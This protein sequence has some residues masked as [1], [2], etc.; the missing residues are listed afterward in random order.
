MVCIGFMIL[1]HEIG[2]VEGKAVFGSQPNSLI[3][4]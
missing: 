3:G 4:L 1:V 2:V